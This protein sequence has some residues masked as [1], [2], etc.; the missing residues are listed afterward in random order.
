MFYITFPYFT[1]CTFRSFIFQKMINNVKQHNVSDFPAP[2][3]ILYNKK[4]KDGVV[5]EIKVGK[6]RLASFCVLLR[7]DFPFR[8]SPRVL[9]VKGETQPMSK[10][11]EEPSLFEEGE[12]LKTIFP[13]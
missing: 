13:A 9:F 12:G 6:K 7:R 5:V 1:I 4:L 8:K 3:Q 11:L 2:M 10:S